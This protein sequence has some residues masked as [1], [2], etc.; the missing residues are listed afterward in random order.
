[1][2]NNS[3]A[4]VAKDMMRS[5]PI[6]VGLII[7]IGGGVWSKRSDSRL[8]DVMVSHPVGAHGGVVQWDFGTR[9]LG[10]LSE[11]DLYTSLELTC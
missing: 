7:G 3:A 4:T 2:G 1:M 10:S 11:W 8:G 6:I 9:S 5:S